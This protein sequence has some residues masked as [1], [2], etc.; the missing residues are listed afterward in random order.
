MSKTGAWALRLW[1]SEPP[2]DPPPEEEQERD[3]AEPDPYDQ[4]DPARQEELEHM[5]I[6]EQN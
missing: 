4:L 5:P 1:G 3:E 6:E 2:V